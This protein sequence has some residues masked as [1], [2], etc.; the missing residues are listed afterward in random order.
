MSF[1]KSELGLMRVLGLS[2]EEAALLT[3]LVENGTP[4]VPEL[5]AR[6][7]DRLIERGI[8]DASVK[9]RGLHERWSDGP[10]MNPAIKWYIISNEEG[11]LRWWMQR[12]PEP[13]WTAGLDRFKAL[14]E[15]PGG[16]HFYETM[17]E[18][19]WRRGP[20]GHPLD[21][22]F[23]DFTERLMVW[24]ALSHHY[25]FG[26]SVEAHQLMR[27]SFLRDDCG[28]WQAQSL[29]QKSHPIYRKGGLEAQ[30][31]HQ[32]PLRASPSAEL[33]AAFQSNLNR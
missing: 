19:L 1:A 31:T 6:A 2:S 11:L 4:E 32:M 5:Y 16:C 28:T 22:M 25:A 33:L 9:S 20:E 18:Y 30:H 24:L 8:I 21:A 26:T 15:D 12:N 29:L 7:Y 17:K 14:A 3:T 27:L 23:P 13:F 10:L